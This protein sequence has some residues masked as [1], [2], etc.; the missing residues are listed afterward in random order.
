MCHTA[1]STHRDRNGGK[2][3]TSSSF[4]IWKQESDNISFGA[5]VAKNDYVDDAWTKL[6]SDFSTFVILSFPYLFAGVW[7]ALAQV[8]K[9][10]ELVV[11][12]CSWIT[13][14]FS[15]VFFWFS[16]VQCTPTAPSIPSELLAFLCFILMIPI[17]SRNARC[18]VNYRNSRSKN[19]VLMNKMASVLFS[20][21][22]YLFN[23]CFM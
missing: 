20:C 3:G 9:P 14:I 10:R 1:H 15:G 23:V 2:N 11:S 19:T 12:A 5:I 16:C 8:S 22:L 6:H 17:Q 21:H 18:E 7:M 4:W 13:I